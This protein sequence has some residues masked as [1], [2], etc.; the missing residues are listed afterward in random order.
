MDEEIK[1]NEKQRELV[2]QLIEDSFNVGQ[3]ICQ[4]GYICKDLI[5]NIKEVREQLG[6]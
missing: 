4:D 2:L 3:W 6:L 5:N 1:L